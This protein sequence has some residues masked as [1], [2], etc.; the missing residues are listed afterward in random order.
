[1]DKCPIHGKSKTLIRLTLQKTN[2]SASSM[3]HLARKGFSFSLASA[4]NSVRH[5]TSFSYPQL[6]SG[7]ITFGNMS[8]MIMEFSVL[9]LVDGGSRTMP[10]I[11]T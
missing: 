2:I 5:S 7:L 6:V 3:G 4:C 1:M 11:I 10:A 8:Q 9:S